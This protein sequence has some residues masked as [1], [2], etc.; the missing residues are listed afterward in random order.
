MRARLLRTFPAFTSRSFRLYFV[1]QFISF[2]GSWSQMTAMMWFV[3]ELTHSAY[4]VGLTSALSIFPT[5]LLAPF[6]GTIIDALPTKT[7]FCVTQ[8]LLMAQAIGFGICVTVH[9]TPYWLVNVLALVL[10]VAN[11]ADTTARHT[12][13]TE[14]VPRELQRSAIPLQANLASIALIAGPALAGIL[15]A[16][17]GVAGTCFVNALSFIPVLVVLPIMRVMES[18]AQN[19]DRAWHA[20]ISGVKYIAAHADLG[21]LLLL[22]GVT[23]FFGFPYRSM[24][25]VFAEDIFHLSPEGFGWLATTPGIGGFVGTILV[26]PLQRRYQ[27]RSLVMSSFVAMGAL[28][29]LFGMTT[30]LWW[31]AVDLFGAG[32]ALMILI[33]LL[34]TLLRL[35]TKPEMQGRVVGFDML[36]FGGGI[37]IGSYIAGY[38]AEHVALAYSMIIPGVGLIVTACVLWCARRRL[39]FII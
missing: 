15:I 6:A 36:V 18:P 1:S 19:G 17:T 20:F 28:L 31:A 10:A 30:S 34:R 35:H 25:P 33:P 3:N 24:L 26:I 21:A 8:I 16:Y 11:A 7:V 32:I 4:D 14:I 9:Y 23:I 38:I 29:I 22:L 39:N 5:A 37:A 2:P 27:V 12:L 13:I